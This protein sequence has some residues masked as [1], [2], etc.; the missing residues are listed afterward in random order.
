MIRL[1]TVPR[2]IHRIP[3]AAVLVLLT[4]GCHEGTFRPGP[5]QP[6]RS[7]VVP[8]RRVGEGALSIHDPGV[9]VIRDAGTWR[10][11]WENFPTY[12][13]RP[14]PAVDFAREMVAAVSLGSMDR[15]SEAAAYVTGVERA[16]DSLFVRMVNDLY[17]DELPI[18]VC[19]S[20]FSPVDLVVLPRSDGPVAFTLTR[21]W[22]PVPP[23]ARWLRP[24]AVAETDTI[25]PDVRTLYRARIARDS[26]TSIDELARLMD[27]LDGEWDRPVAAAL[28]ENPRVQASPELLVRLARPY[29]DG[30]DR[31][32]QV[33]LRRH[34]ARLA[35]D[36][37]TGREVLR[38]LLEQLDRE[39]SGYREVAAAIVRHPVLLADRQLLWTAYRFLLRKHITCAEGQRLFDRINPP[40]PGAPRAS[41][42]Q[43]WDDS[44]RPPGLRP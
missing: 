31:L 40:D 13:T 26:A 17:S 41:V 9:L 25:P 6:A 3:L 37:A 43:P 10:A 16:G 32:A 24:M 4:A 42:C 7:E 35:R 39:E 22:T 33:L 5:E 34:G 29:D 1:L 28:V 36:S 23:L 18:L 12:E 11:L 8:F 30:Q 15:C 38:L 19:D 27:R 21:A 20:R 44:P 14:A 2:R